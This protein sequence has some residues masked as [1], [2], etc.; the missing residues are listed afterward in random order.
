MNAFVNVSL[1]DLNFCSVWLTVFRV[2]S[3]LLRLI[4]MKIAFVMKS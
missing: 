4:V 3:K 2:L 1:F